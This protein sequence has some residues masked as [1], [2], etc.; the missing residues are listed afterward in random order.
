MI[1]DDPLAAFFDQP[2]E[3]TFGAVYQATKRLVWTLCLRILRD[4]TDASD[5]FQ[6]AYCRLLAM[7][8]VGRRTLEVM[9]EERNREVAIPGTVA[10]HILSEESSA[11]RDVGAA[12]VGSNAR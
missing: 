7:A 12:V 4:R 3:E 5:A 1:Q 6:S 8:R 2:T 11:V 10:P 9:A